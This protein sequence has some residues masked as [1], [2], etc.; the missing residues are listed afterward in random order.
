MILM[1]HGN[2]FRYIERHIKMIDMLD[3]MLDY[4]AS[5]WTEKMHE[6][7]YDRLMRYALN[8]M[9]LVS[10][11]DMFADKTPDEIFEFIYAIGEDL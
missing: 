10:G 1:G 5:D 7:N 9:G 8:A 11:L 6:M 2:L 4:G 3:H